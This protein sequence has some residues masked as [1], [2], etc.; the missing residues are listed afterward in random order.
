MGTSSAS[1]QYT[2]KIITAGG[3][4]PLYNHL[5]NV[6][7]LTITTDG[8]APIVD[9][10]NYVTA[11][12]VMSNTTQ[13]FTATGGIRGRGN[14]TWTLDKKPYKIKFDSKTQVLG[15]PKAKNWDILANFMDS[16]GMRNAIAGDVANH[17]SLAWTPRS[18]FIEVT[19]NGAALGLY[20]I[21]EHVEIG[22]NRLN[23]D[24][25]ADTDVSGLALTGGYSME[26]DVRMEENNEPGF[27]TKLNVPV[28]LDEPDGSVYV[29]YS[30]IRDFIQEFE[31]MLF[32]D[33]FADPDDGYAKYID[34]NSFIDWYWVNELIANNDS[35]FGASVKLYKK[36]DT[37]D[38]P[39]KLYLGPVWD[40]DLSISIG[41]IY[42]YHDADQWWTRCGA[43]WIKRLM[44]DSA[45]MALF[46]SRWTTLK[47]AI[48][49]GNHLNLFIDQL[50]ILLGPELTRD[51]KIWS[52]TPGANATAAF[53]ENWLA[54][55]IAF[56]DSE[57][58][59][60]ADT[61]APSVPTGLTSSNVT[62][63]SLTLSWDDATDSVTDHLGVTGYRILRDGVIC[64]LTAI[65]YSDTLTSISVSHLAPNTSYNFTVQSRDATG[66]WSAESAPL[67][68][69][70]SARQ[71]SSNGLSV[72]LDNA[73]DGTVTVYNDG[74]PTITLGN[75]FYV[76]GPTAYKRQC[77]GGRFWCP[78][79]A[80]LPGTVTLM[81][82]AFTG[83]VG[84]AAFDLSQ[85][86]LRS[87]TVATTGGPGWVEAT[88]T[89]FDMQSGTPVLIAY[90]FP[91]A[92]YDYLYN[93]PSDSNAWHP[94]DVASPGVYMAAVSDQTPG[95]IS[96]SRAYFI[97]GSGQG[98]SSAYYGTDILVSDPY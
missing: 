31:D 77:I 4:T 70:T 42:A 23:I 78:S 13:S 28:T 44:E 80:S 37:A 64:G 52:Y 87:A 61:V 72:L 30:Y 16:S 65:P 45:C 59:S 29:Q 58:A 38:S 51:Q 83:L 48:T 84:N 1:Q 76:F 5:L 18:Q 66:N 34:V 20:Q 25:M 35:G 39:G 2:P 60:P 89:P 12:F 6:P 9:K 27:R 74:T 81:A 95:G 40:H 98:T 63:F 68:V 67:E 17:T 14:S 55:R 43:S 8:G 11:T 50:A 85:P 32:S 90:Q 49:S 15:M 62:P 21:Y 36:R 3:E 41:A 46:Q 96:F 19:L 71:G 79:G 53:I 86:P 33:D 75:A 94:Y 24:E 57:F 22:S 88:W 93:S 69:T 54:A 7:I 56:I 73:P 91:D 10:E 97:Q 47:N 92:P 26:I 82:F